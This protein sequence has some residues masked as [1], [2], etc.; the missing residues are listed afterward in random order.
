MISRKTTLAKVLPPPSD[1]WQLEILEILE[2]LEARH[3]LR[4]GILF[5]FTVGEYCQVEIITVTCGK[6][7]ARQRLSRR[8][9]IESIGRIGRGGA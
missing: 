7:K 8:R 5:P 4:L 3:H 6:K 9:G 1:A 2:A